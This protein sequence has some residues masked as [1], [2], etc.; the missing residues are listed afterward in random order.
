MTQDTMIDPSILD[1]YNQGNEQTRLTSGVGMLEYLRTRHILTRFLPPAPA[2][3][4]DIGGGAGVYALPLAAMGYDVHLIDPVPL[5]ITQAIA[6]ADDHDIML[7]SAAVG[8]AR[9]LTWQDMSV[10]VV[11]LLGPLYHLPDPLDRQRALS[12]AFRVLRPRGVIVVATIS[13]FTSTLA[14][15][16]WNGVEESD[17]IQSVYQAIDHGARQSPVS[18]AHRP[19]ELQHEVLAANFHL[20]ALVAV[21]GMGELVP[22]FDSVLANPRQRATLLDVLYKL[23]AEIS[24]LGASPHVMAIGHKP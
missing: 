4:L 5:H 7:G 2:R 1:Y 23:E 17:F 14:R 13:R 16:R 6:A 9:V 24:I 12:E 3:V 22:D 21:E 20:D 19:L 10:D 18:Y 8:D 15:L 11:L